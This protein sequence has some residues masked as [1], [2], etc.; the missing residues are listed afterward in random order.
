MEYGVIAPSS[1]MTEPMLGDGPG[2]GRYITPE[3]MYYYMIYWDKIVI[4]FSSVTQDPIPYGYK[5][6][7]SGFVFRPTIDHKESLNKSFEYFFTKGAI[8]FLYEQ[9]IAAKE[10]IEE[11]DGSTDWVIHQI[12]DSLVLPDEYKREFRTLRTRL[13]N[14]LPVPNR[15]VEIEEVLRFR[16]ERRD[17]RLALHHYLEEL[18]LDA[19]ENPDSELAE[20]RAVRD[21]ES[22]IED[23]YEVSDSAWDTHTSFDFSVTFNLDA[24]RITSAIAGGLIDT[25]SGGQ[26]A[27]FGT[28]AGLAPMVS[29]SAGLSSSFEPAERETKLSYL[30]SAHDE[31]IL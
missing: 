23:I 20:R 31:N 8:N 6:V 25:Y 28:L 12:G 11:D 3:E 7:D 5:L 10:L 19:V 14:A 27:P 18:Y 22:A 29:I 9:V 15:E 24:P 17:E 16:E 13:S 1:I 2:W 4:P 30:A 21:L 26:T